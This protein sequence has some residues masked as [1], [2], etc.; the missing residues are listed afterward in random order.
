MS[1]SS[2]RKVAYHQSL[3]IKMSDS[4]TSDHD[5]EEELEQMSIYLMMKAVEL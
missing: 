4:N 3:L 1:H 2:F 5:S